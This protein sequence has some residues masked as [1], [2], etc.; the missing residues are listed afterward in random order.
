[1]KARANG[2]FAPEHHEHDQERE[3]QQHD[4]E[5]LERAPRNSPGKPRGRITNDSPM[6]NDNAIGAPSTVDGSR[7]S[8]GEPS[9]YWSSRNSVAEIE[10]H[11]PDGR[12]IAETEPDAQMRAV[13]AKKKKKKVGAV[14]GETSLVSVNTTPEKAPEIGY[15]S[16]TEASREE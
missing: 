13:P 6:P 12:F 15:R 3:D 8:S 10:A 14:A 1:M 7:S 5:H 2:R 16:S 11:R 9:G 4:P